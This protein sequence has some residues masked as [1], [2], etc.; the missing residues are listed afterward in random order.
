MQHFVN[1]R[2]SLLKQADNLWLKEFFREKIMNRY[3]RILAQGCLFTLSVSLASCGLLETLN[4]FGG[5]SPDASIDPA[6]QAPGQPA[7]GE[8]PFAAMTAPPFTAKENFSCR[9]PNYVV[10]VAWQQDQP[11]MS[12]GRQN[13]APTVQN[14]VAQVKNN[15]DGSFTYELSQDAVF[16]ARVFPDRTCFIQVVNPANN[17]VAV[18]EN[19]RLG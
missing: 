6:A 18:E 17:T 15:P 7:S 9:T 8:A 4:P 11:A 19:G 13:E 5:S 2:L 10:S 3:R 1:R 12:F 14:A 16:Y